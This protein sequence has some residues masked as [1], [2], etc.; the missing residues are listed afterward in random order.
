MHASDL[1]NDATRWLTQIATSDASQSCRN[2]DVLEMTRSVVRDIVLDMVGEIYS[3]KIKREIAPRTTVIFEH[4][5]NQND[6]KRR[7]VPLG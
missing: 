1:Q 3:P 7:T 2:A 5:L 4:E 6:F